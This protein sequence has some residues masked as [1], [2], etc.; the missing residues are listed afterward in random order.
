MF[1]FKS[2]QLKVA[3]YS[4][5]PNFLKETPC[6]KQYEFTCIKSK[7]CIPIYDVCN[8]FEDCDDKTDEIDCKSTTISSKTTTPSLKTT[9]ALIDTDLESKIVQENN[10]EVLEKDKNIK[11]DYEDEYEISKQKAELVD[12]LNSLISERKK[13]KVVQ[14]SPKDIFDSYMRTSVIKSITKKTISKATSTTKKMIF[15]GIH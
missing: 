2:I 15:H 14:N 1:I 13:N 11:P 12:Y 7:K 10:D 8:S 3:S 5:L 9:V 6:H 4:F